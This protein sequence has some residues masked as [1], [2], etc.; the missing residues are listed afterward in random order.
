MELVTEPDLYS[1]SI[2]DKGNYVDKIPSFARIKKGL[3]CPCG[4]RKDKVYETYSVF[5]G[6]IKTKN[7]QKWLENLNLNKAN[8]YIENEQLK[9]TLQNQ[10]IIIAKMEKEIIIKSKTIDYLTNQ[11]TAPSNFS[12]TN[13]VTNLLDFD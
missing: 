12:H 2:D 6:H 9:E 1:P 3:S 8:Y 11:L 5:S 7:H 13:V 4:A 10:R